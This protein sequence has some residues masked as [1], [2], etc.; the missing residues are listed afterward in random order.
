I[1][2]ALIIAGWC[3]TGFFTAILILL[4]AVMRKPELV[5]RWGLKIAGLV[6]KKMKEEKQ[7][8]MKESVVTGVDQ[9]YGTFR[10]FAGKARWGLAVGFLFSLLFWTCEYSIASIIMVGLGF[11][12]NILLSIVFQLIIAVVLMIPIT[13]GG[14]GVAEAVY[15]GFYSLLGLGNML[16]PFVVLLRLVLYYSNLIIGFVASFI[17]VKRE[18]RMKKVIPDEEAG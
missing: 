7:E 14:T 18:A 4:V 13:P 5:K 15:G 3:G 2:S 6:S 12:P 16:G 17:I 1:D 11:P 10:H 8:K 9:F